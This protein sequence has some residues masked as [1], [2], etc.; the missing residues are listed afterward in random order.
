MTPHGCA[1]PLRCL[2]FEV[3]ARPVERPLKRHD[4]DAAGIEIGPL[5][6]SQM[7]WVAELPPTFTQFLVGAGP[8]NHERLGFGDDGTSHLLPGLQIFGYDASHDKRCFP[9]QK[10]ETG[11]RFRNRQKLSRSD[12]ISLP[13]GN[14]KGRRVYECPFLPSPQSASPCHP[15][16][17]CGRPC[18]YSHEQGCP[19]RRPASP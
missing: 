19:C 17:A 16:R 14:R 11:L 6:K 10:R 8:V 3:L 12:F 18:I 9:T 4:L 13:S 7:K 2:D 15:C 5:G 1:E